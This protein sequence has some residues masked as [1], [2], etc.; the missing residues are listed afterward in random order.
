VCCGAQHST[1]CSLPTPSSQDVLAAFDSVDVNV[2][3]LAT[4]YLKNAVNRHWRPRKEGLC[5][6]TK[7]AKEKTSLL[8]P[9]SCVLSRRSVS[10]AEKHTLRER[11]PALA[12]SE[13]VPQVALQLCLVVARLARFDHPRDWCVL[14]RLATP[15]L[16]LCISLDAHAT[17]SR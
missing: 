9:L 4:L 6:Q 10:D 1:D 16:L 13:A 5:V 11:I 15:C 7:P 3:L 8:T 14:R 2:R 17:R 12:A